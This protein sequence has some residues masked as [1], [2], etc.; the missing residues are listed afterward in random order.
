M[1]GQTTFT[2]GREIM[3]QIEISVRIAPDL[4]FRLWIAKNLFALAAYIAN[5]K[6]NFETEEIAE[7]EKK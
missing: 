4:K 1:K 7:A 6:L 5:F 2:I 3:E